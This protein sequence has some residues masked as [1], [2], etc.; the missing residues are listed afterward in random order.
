MGGGTGRGRGQG[1]RSRPQ[2]RP[3]LREE[4][5]QESS[6]PR[7]GNSWA[8]R[9]HRVPKGSGKGGCQFG[10]N[11]ETNGIAERAGCGSAGRSGCSSEAGTGTAAPLLFV[12]NLPGNI[13]AE[14]LE[15]VFA[16]YGKV[17]KVYV[18][19]GR[20]AELKACAFVKYLLDCEAAEAQQALHGRYEAKPGFGPVVVRAG[21]PGIFVE[22]LPG[23]IE[24]AILDYVFSFY[25]HVQTVHITAPATR[26]SGRARAFVEY[27]SLAEVEV[28]K[29]ALY[30]NAELHALSRRRASD[31]DSPRAAPRPEAG[32]AGN[33]ER[34]CVIC[35]S[36]SQTH[37][38]VPCGHR[39]VCQE[40]G[41]IVVS[42]AIC[43]ACPICR[44]PVEQVL[45]IFC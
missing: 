23:D 14:V 35:M 38:F 30:E 22:N 4:P 31:G 42:K 11:P 6:L 5:S 43:A 3:T 20:T 8:Q 27:S 39:C 44:M 34:V 36:S 37:A 29:A 12:K 18:L 9:A 41:D 45:R 2:G 1:A 32:D 40:C 16:N 28:A 13:A 7:R 33:G 17:V 26:R 21:V 25:G 10:N 15:T 24:E 19:S